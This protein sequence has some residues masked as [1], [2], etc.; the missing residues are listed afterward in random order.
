MKFLKNI[1]PP[2]NPIKVLFYPAELC[3]ITNKPIS[4]N[5]IKVLFYLN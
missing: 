1:N 3:A 5:P 2:F 4:F